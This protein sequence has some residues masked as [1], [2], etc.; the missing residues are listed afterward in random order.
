MTL[1]E[2]RYTLGDKE[3]VLRSATEADAEMLQRYIK[4]VTGET[5][6]LMCESDEMNTTAEDE[7]EFIKTHRDSPD[8]MLIEGFIVEEVDGV[9]APMKEL[10]EAGDMRIELE[11]A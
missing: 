2:Q 4:T 9:T 8:E 3:L 11:L 1:K 5:R 7:L 6:F 10:E